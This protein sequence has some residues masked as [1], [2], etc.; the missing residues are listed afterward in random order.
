MQRR[1]FLS[2]LSL[3][4]AAVA[5]SRGALAQQ[6]VTKSIL[7]YGAKPD[8]KSLSTKAIQRAIDELSRAGG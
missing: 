2:R 3:A 1:D 4:M 7:D 8:G 5:T 6:A